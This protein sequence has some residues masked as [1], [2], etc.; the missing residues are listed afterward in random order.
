MFRGQVL[1]RL[2]H[3]TRLTVSGNLPYMQLTSRKRVQPMTNRH[4][5]TESRIIARRPFDLEA[6]QSLLA[7]EQISQR[8]AQV[9]VELAKVEPGSRELSIKAQMLWHDARTTRLNYEG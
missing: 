2:G 8:V 3:A 4:P 7:A 1:S 5:T 6:Y 9:A